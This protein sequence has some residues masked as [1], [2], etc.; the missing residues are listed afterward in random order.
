MKAKKELQKQAHNEHKRI[1]DNN[2][3]F[4]E[5]YVNKNFKEESNIKCS[6]SKNLWAFASLAIIILFITSVFYIFPTIFNNNRD[7]IDNIIDNNN[8]DND[9]N[10]GDNNQER[11]YFQDDERDVESSLSDLNELLSNSIIHFSEDFEITVKLKY[12]SIT[13]DKLMFII[14]AFN[15]NTFEELYMYVVVNKDYIFDKPINN[16]E[17]FNI[18]IYEGIYS[19]L[20]EIDDDLYTFKGKAKIEMGEEIIFIDYEQ[21]SFEENS[22]FISTITEIIASK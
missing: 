11:R 19:E 4:Y 22:Y 13:D 16:D 2:K 9:G 5:D 1:L 7:N 10:N 8:G 20:T 15:E 18:G 12:D 14:T 21:I 17:K 3:D 6:S